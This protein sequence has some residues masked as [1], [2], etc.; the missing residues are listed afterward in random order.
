LGLGRVPLTASREL[1]EPFPPGNALPVRREKLEPVERVAAEF[2]AAAGGGDAAAHASSLRRAL[3]IVDLDGLPVAEL[4]RV[5]GSV[6]QALRPMADVQRPLLAELYRPRLLKRLAERVGTALAAGGHLAGDVVA[7]RVEPL[8]LS[9]RRGG[10]GQREGD[11]EKEGAP[12]GA[13]IR[14]P[15]GNSPPRKG[16]RTSDG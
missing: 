2:E 10:D 15:R 11:A 6:A 12:H 5:L 14:P 16:G 9:E 3:E 1:D 4:E 13:T 7:R 8:D